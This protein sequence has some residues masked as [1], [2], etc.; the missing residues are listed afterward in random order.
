VKTS[1][2][3]IRADL[4]SISAAI[5]VLS[6]EGS[7]IMKLFGRAASADLADLAALASGLEDAGNDHDR[8]AAV[9][10]IHDG[11]V[12]ENRAASFRQWSRQ[13]GNAANLVLAA[14]E[15]LRQQ[16]HKAPGA[17]FLHEDN[18]G[19]IIG[20]ANGRL[21]DDEPLATVLDLSGLAEVLRAGRLAGLTELQA[22]PAAAI[23]T[24]EQINR[25]YTDRL[26]N[27][28]PEIRDRFVDAILQAV[29]LSERHPTWAARWDGFMSRIDVAPESWLEATGIPRATYPRWILVLRYTA[30]EARPL[31]RPTQLEAGWF[32]FHFPSPPAGSAGAGGHA[33]SL[34]ERDDNLRLAVLPEFIHARVRFRLQ[35]WKASGRMCGVTT[36]IVGLGG[37]LGAYRAAHYGDLVADY[38]Q[39]TLFEWMAR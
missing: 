38:G 5:L 27:P 34:G 18:G 29:Y 1:P 21:A 28:D 22:L 7:R 15:Y 23:L 9:N 14:E 39:E 24:D 4:E 35:H 6:R 33:M 36:R 13:S 30:G 26:R 3:D 10:F 37:R 20:S 19:N 2:L 8:A 32:G 12:S 11:R 17:T 25:F 16:V 31:V